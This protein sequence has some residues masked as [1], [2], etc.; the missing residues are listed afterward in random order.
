MC[1]VSTI[2]TAFI[3]F[4]SSSFLLV[5]WLPLLF[6]AHAHQFL[7]RYIMLITS[8]SFCYRII[9]RHATMTSVMY[10]HYSNWQL[11]QWKWFIFNSW[12]IWA[13]KLIF[14]YRLRACWRDWSESRWAFL[15]WR[16]FWKSACELCDFKS[17]YFPIAHKHLIA[18]WIC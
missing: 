13:A 6:V 8:E 7:R 15:A 18:I 10:Y 14:C 3:S 2:I 5:Y 11:V 12:L 9:M 4:S 17:N 16:Q 1:W